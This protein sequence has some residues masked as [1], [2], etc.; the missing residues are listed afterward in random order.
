M[1]GWS[2]PTF[3]LLSPNIQWLVYSPPI[4]LP[5]PAQECPGHLAWEQGPTAALTLSSLVYLLQYC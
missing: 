2:S 4:H 5:P 1:S 3:V